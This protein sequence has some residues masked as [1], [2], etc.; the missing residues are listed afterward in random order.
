[1]ADT[2]SIGKSVQQY[3]E[4]QLQQARMAQQAALEKGYPE[5]SLLTQA[6][7][8]GIPSLYMYGDPEQMQALQRMG[9]LYGAYGAAG[10]YD[11]TQYGDIAD[12]YRKAGLYDKA[13]YGDIADL[14]RKA[15]TYDKT[16]YGDIADLYR[17]AAGYDKTQF[18]DIAAKYGAAG[19]YGPT[20][21]ADIESQAVAGAKYDPAQFARSDYTTRNIQERM[22]PYEELVSQRQKARLEKAYQEGRGQR[23]LEAIRSNTFGG[24]GR[25]VGEE[26]ARRDYLDRLA[27][28]E[29]QSL[30]SSYES[31]VGLYGKEM[32]D[33]M[34]AQQAEEQSRQFSQQAGVQGIEAML[35]A[36]QAQEASRQFGKGAEFQGLAGEMSAREQQA[37]QEAAAKEAELAGIAGLASTRQQEAAQIAAAKEAE[38]QGLAGL[39]GTREQEAAQTAAAKEAELQGLSGLMGTRQQE[40]A[41]TAA[42]KEAQFAGLAGQTDAAAR[43]AALAEQRKN[44]QIANLAAAQAGGQQQEAYNLSKTLYPLDIATAGA[45]IGAT[46]AGNVVENLPST[47]VQQPSTW[48]NILAGGTALGGIAQ[49]FGGL[50]GIGSAIGGIG[51]TIGGFLGGAAGGLVPY[52]LQYHYRGGGLADL[53]PEYYDSYER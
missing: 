26:I 33:L 28:L 4:E 49:G 31:A 38:L 35:A 1:M 27:D 11:K 41:Q 37:A 32:A 34:A 51:K 47:K 50:S 7:Y 45:N 10:G 19:Q 14:Y 43:Q 52:G 30:Q 3:T 44:M 40:A 23:E 17:Q 29:A 46:A 16:A 48:Q 36:R 39:M 9:D 42:A 21:Y 25:A 13:Q 5:E 24:S 8:S 22:S 53:E 20:S 12:L 18:G 2:S 15:G 6:Y